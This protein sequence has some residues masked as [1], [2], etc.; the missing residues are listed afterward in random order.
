[1]LAELDAGGRWETGKLFG[2]TLVIN[3]LAN[4]ALISSEDLSI[5]SINT[6]LRDLFLVALEEQRQGATAGIQVYVP[7]E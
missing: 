2:V 4:F 7:L 3:L 5:I 6:K 1:M